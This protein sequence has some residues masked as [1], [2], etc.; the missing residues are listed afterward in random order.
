MLR[1]VLLAPAVLVT[2][3]TS[4]FA[5]EVS[6][7][8]FLF[9]KIAPSAQTNGTGGALTLAGMNDPLAMIINPASL[10]MAAQT[11]RL[12]TAFYPWRTE[13]LPQFNLSDLTYSSRALFV[14]TNVGRFCHNKEL[15]FYVGIGYNEVYLNLGATERH[16]PENEPLGSFHSWE[17]ARGITL[18]ASTTW[19]LNASVGWTIKQATSHLS[20]GGGEGEPESSEAEESMQ[21]FGFVLAL[22]IANY[23]HVAPLERA[24]LR[25]WLTPSYGYALTNVGGD[26]HY[27]DRAQ[28]DPLP[29][30]S[31]ATIALST[32]LA[33]ETKT[34]DWPLVAFEWAV[35]GESE[36]IWRDPYGH[37]KYRRA[38]GDLDVVN[39]LILNRTNSDIDKEHGWEI[40]LVD[41]VILRGGRV[42]GGGDW[43]YKTDGFGLRFGSFFRLLQR[44]SSITPEDRA[45]TFLAE[46]IEIEYSQSHWKVTNGYMPSNNTTFRQL[47][48]SY[49]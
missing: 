29:R 6:Q 39:D 28:G 10:G 12:A 2:L 47:V 20:P 48:L 42:E 36:L 11:T 44:T 5:S 18:A 3:I 24:F 21:D 49:R 22:P 41:F 35:Q 8:T 16:G 32:G 17:R 34:K 31:R 9:L 40:G 46:H 1:H 4:S 30:T 25:P 27:F 14:G 43:G 15:P 33:L 19:P 45:L 38:V 37:Y 7:A 26:V 13:W 23:L